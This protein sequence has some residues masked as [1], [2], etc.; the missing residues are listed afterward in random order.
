MTLCTRCWPATRNWSAIWGLAP[1]PP[2]TRP[3]RNEPQRGNRLWRRLS[4]PRTA[5][6]RHESKTACGWRIPAMI[7]LRY[8]ALLT[9]L[10]A[11]EVF[12][13]RPY[14]TY[15]LTFPDGILDHVDS[16]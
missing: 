1:Q 10:R 16:M 14:E 4:Y 11:Y 15:S 8:I 2:G 5:W 6:W 7:H 3:T 13:S 9:H 12:R